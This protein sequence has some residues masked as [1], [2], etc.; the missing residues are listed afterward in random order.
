MH[1]STAGQSWFKKHQL[2]IAPWLFVAPAL[3]FFSIYVIIPIFQSISISFYE[4][5]G[6]YNAA[7]E[8]TATWVGWDNYVKLMDDERFYTSLKN[9]LWVGYSV[10]SQSNRDRHAIL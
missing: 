5:N 2:Q 9:N 1:Q 6:L 4:W 8:S 3:I 10:V 7:G